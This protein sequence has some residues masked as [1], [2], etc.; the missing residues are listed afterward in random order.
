MRAVFY[1]LGSDGT[2]GANKNSIKIIGEETDRYAQ[3]YFV[4]DSKKSGSVTVSHLRFGPRPIRAT[5]PDHARELRRLPPVL[6]SSSA[7]TCSSAA[8][9]G[10][11]LPAEQPLRPPT[12]SGTTCRVACSRR[13]STKR[14][15]LFVD[16]RRRRSRATAGMGGRINTVM[17]TCFFALSGVLPRDE[18]IAA[19]KHVD[20]EDLRQARRGRRAQ[21]LRR[22]RRGARRLHEVG[23]AAHGH[24]RRWSAVRPS[25]PRRR[26]S[27]SDVT[28]E[29]IAGRGDALPVS[30]LPVDGTFPTG[31][32]RWEKRD[33][34]QRDPGLGPRR[35]H[36]V[37]QVRRWSA[38]TR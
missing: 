27:C 34:A 33:I 28:A 21:E 11:H 6:A 25:R 32:A 24:Q 3:G 37:R 16:R 1:G 4:Y 15:R 13:S 17:Q 26:T 8:E 36:P 14:L 20:R 22:R 2:V 31:T 9:P 12:R 7:S 10:A 35:L 30:A 18:A 29:M 38:R 19:I 23:T 5:L